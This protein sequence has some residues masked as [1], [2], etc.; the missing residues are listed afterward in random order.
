MEQ[1]GEPIPAPSTTPEVDP[2]TAAGY[3]VRSVTA[4]IDKTEAF[5]H[6]L[7]LFPEKGLDLDPEKVRKERLR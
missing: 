5:K 4:K 6:F 3:L 7:S 1:D 2:E